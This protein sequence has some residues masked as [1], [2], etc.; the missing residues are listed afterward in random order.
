MNDSKNSSSRP[1]PRPGN[2]QPPKRPSVSRP[3]FSLGRTPALDPRIH[4]FRG[5]RADIALADRLALPHYIAP[6]K[7]QIVVPV[8][9]LRAD[10]SDEA[11]LGSQLLHGERFALLADENGWA[12]GY[13]AH[14][15]FVGFLRP[16][17][18]G[19]VSEPSHVVAVPQTES[20]LFLASR[21]G[22]TI[23]GEILDTGTGSIPLADLLPI[24]EKVDDPVAIAES[25]IGAP[26]LLGGRS[27]RGIDCSGLVQIAFGMAG[28]AVPRDSDL[29]LAAIGTD[30]AEGD[31]LRRGDIVFFPAHVG[32]MTDGETL[33]HASGHAGAVTSEP[34]AQAVARI[35]EKHNRP[36]LAK[37]RVKL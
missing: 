9:D 28:L 23:D 8:A 32:M 37:R 36:V 1:S 14:D 34:L 10:P 16:D 20:G 2:P 29:Q 30:I 27:A 19:P 35:A 5:D 12:W 33:L 24:G 3:S 21:V 11:E 22:G 18:L 13:G 7:R 31:P 4:A 15:G 25:L 6:A 26:Y 17:A